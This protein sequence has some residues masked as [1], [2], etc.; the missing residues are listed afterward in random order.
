[1]SR[2]KSTTVT[3]EDDRSL[4]FGR[5]RA[6]N[7]KRCPEAFHPLNDWSATDWATAAAW[8]L[9]EALN[10]IKKLRRGEKVDRR[11]IGRELAD[12]VTYIDLL[13]ARLGIDLGGMVVEKFNLVSRR[14]NSKVGL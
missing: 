3:I 11:A 12:A 13:A 8:E 5:L 6:A 9:G 1:M 4:S 10:L 14:R 7:L 2:S